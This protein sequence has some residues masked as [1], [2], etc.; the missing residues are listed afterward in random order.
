[1]ARASPASRAQTPR[2]LWASPS[3]LS[4]RGL[5]GPDRGDRDG[6]AVG[7]RHRRAPPYRQPGQSRHPCGLLQ[8]HRAH[9]RGMLAP[10]QA[11]LHRAMLLLGGLEQRRLRTLLWRPR[12]GQDCPSGRVFSRDEGFCVPA[13]PRTD[14]DLGGLAWRW[15]ASTRPLWGSPDRH[16]LIVERR[17]APRAGRTAPPPR[18]TACIGIDG[19]GGGPGKPAGFDALERLGDPL[20]LFG[21]GRR[22]DW[23]CLLGQLAGTHD[24]QPPRCHRVPPGSVCHRDEAEDPRPVPTTRRL[25]PRPAWL[26]A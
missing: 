10:A 15:T 13:P 8:P 11:W 1:M 22:G 12:R 4:G 26:C 23:G 17:R 9:R 3:G 21:L 19:G 18:P 25:L 16:P 2:L 5:A 24:E 7:S 14:R 20:G 6:P